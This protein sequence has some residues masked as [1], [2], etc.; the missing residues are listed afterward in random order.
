MK[1]RDVY[2]KGLLDLGYGY[3]AAIITGLTIYTA[4]S[5]SFRARDWA[6][7]ALAAALLSIEGVIFNISPYMR[8]PL[9]EESARRQR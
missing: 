7:V 1:R 5:I 2:F 9:P 3:T 4:I 6:A 8:K